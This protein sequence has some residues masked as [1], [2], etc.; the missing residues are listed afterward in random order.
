MT[1]LRGHDLVITVGGDGTFLRTAS[2]L[3]TNQLILG[4]NSV[5]E[6]STGALCAI[7]INEFSQIVPQ[8]MNGDYKIFKMPRIAIHINGKK[9]P[10]EAINDVLFTNGSPAATSRYIISFKRKCEEHKSS[11]IWISTASG[12]TAAIH[13]A[14]GTIQKKNDDRLQL[15]VREPYQGIYNPY[16]ITRLF[17]KKNEKVSLI[18]KMIK[19]SIYLD[20]PT[21]H[22]QILYGDHI[23][24]SRSTRNVHTIKF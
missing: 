14:G 23:T 18:S 15:L 11:G 4:I 24:F 5:P 3:K 17:L 13:A 8:L 21:T 2:H 22:C 19:S 20:G 1:P 16:K 7:K 6:V 9:L 10:I 12:S